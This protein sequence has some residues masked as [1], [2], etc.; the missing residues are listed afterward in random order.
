MG[1]FVLDCTGE[2]SVFTQGQ[3]MMLGL[4]NEIQRLLIVSAVKEGLAASREKGIVGGRPKTCRENIPDI[5]YKYY[6][7]YKNNQINKKEFSRLSKLSYPS[8]YKYLDIVE[9]NNN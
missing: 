9:K 8:I 1:D 2:I 3:I 7:M 6:P 4:I 5:F